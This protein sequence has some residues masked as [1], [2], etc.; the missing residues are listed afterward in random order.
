MARGS[1][2]VFEQI[3][4]SLALSIR[5]WY[6][7]KGRSC[8]RSETMGDFALLRFDVAVLLATL[9]PF[10][11]TMISFMITWKGGSYI[12]VSLPFLLVLVSLAFAYRYENAFS[13]LIPA[14]KGS[15]AGMVSLPFVC[16]F[17]V[18]TSSAFFGW[19]FWLATRT[20][21]PGHLSLWEFARGE[22]LS[23]SRGRLG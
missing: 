4:E 5:V 22:R 17:L 8:A 21:A 15:S 2:L 3:E 14:A 19:M 7:K 10:L 18:P 6:T 20:R 13:L 1:G 23:L 9:P 12:R 11:L 16:L